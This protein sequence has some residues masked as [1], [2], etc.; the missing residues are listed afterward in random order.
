MVAIFPR[1][2]SMISSS[3]SSGRGR[4]SRKRLAMKPSH[5]QAAIG[6]ASIAGAHKG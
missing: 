4:L 6:Q 5:C 1:S 3:L 2:A